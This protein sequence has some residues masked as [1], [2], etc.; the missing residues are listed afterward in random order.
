[1]GIHATVPCQE[2]HTNE[3]K[4]EF[5][6]LRTDCFG[7]HQTDYNNT[8]AP[9]HRQTGLGTD[10]Q[11]CHAVNAVNWG[12]SGVSFAGSFD[13]AKTGF[14]LLG[15]HA[16]T[17]CVQCHVGNK[18]LPISTT[19]T[20][21]HA[22][23]FASAAAPPH[24][25]FSTDCT[26]CHTMTSWIPATFDHNNT[27]F[28]LTG[29]HVTV[30]CQQCHVNNVFAG[31]T[32]TCY[33]CHQQQFTSA[34]TPVPHTGFPT[35]CTGCHTTNP[36]WG[37]SI[38]NHQTSSFPLVGAHV[39]LA[40]AQCH[41]NNQYVGLTT[42]CIGCHQV[43]FTN[44]AAPPHT[45]FATDCT[46]CHTTTVW[47]PAIFDHN[48]TPFPLTGGHTTVAACAT[49][50]VNNVYAGLSTAC[51][52]CHQAQFTTAT[53]PVAHT[54]FPTD[55]SGC[56][57]TNPGWGPSTFNHNNT[58]F[59][60][61]GGHTA[62]AAC[63][64]CH[65]NNVYAGLS[66]A[67]YSCHQAQFTTATTPVAHTGFPTDCSGCHT[68][69]P[70][71]GP[72]T[73]NH[74]TSSFPLVGAHISLAC[75]QCHIN[76]QYVGL[77]T[78][79]IGCH[80]V[81]FTNAAAPPH[82]GFATD[83]TTCHTTTVWQ[84]ATFDHNTTPFPL[85]GGHTTVAACVTCHVNNV[86]AGLSTACY[87]CHQ[88]QFTSATTPVPHTGFPTDCSGCHTTNPGWGPSTFNHQTSAFPLVGAH[89]SLTCAQCHINSQY[90]GLSTTCIGCHQVDFTNAASPPHT[91]F[92][93]DCTTCHSNTAWQPATFNHNTTPFPLTGAHATVPLCAT[94]HVNN[95]FAGL[96]TSC[97][98]CHQSQFTSATTPVPHTGFATDCSTCHTTNPGWGP[99][100]F[101]HNTMFALTG[102]HMAVACTQCHVSNQY[103]GL[104]TTCYGCHTQDF[105]TAAAPPHTGF[106]TDCTTCHTGG[107]WQPATFNHN[108]TP[109]PLTGGHATVACALCHVNNVFVGLTT[110]CYTCHTTTFTNAT[111]PV[112][113]TGFPTACA[114]CHTTNPG[115]TPSTFT[116]ANS[117]PRFPQDSRHTT[118]ACAKCHQ[119]ATNYTAY[120]CTNSG[121]HN[122][123]QGGD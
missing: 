37:P 3:Q 5:T 80:Q 12:V 79:C 24:T 6:G 97:Y 1:V 9:N 108:T 82:T 22:Q 91:G 61:T 35:D 46:T 75:A 23:V 120:C 62:V 86:Y 70:G 49:C 16:A 55:C 44:A 17:A 90:V 87:S 30:T 10:C 84:P 11:S 94:C 40:C 51:Y 85:T 100:T 71:W 65:V 119:T 42:T 59:P 29:G 18:F 95:V 2:C 68:T 102:A 54:G 88:T 114:T 104:A 78:T 105:S 63:A 48:N 101:N 31:L 56:H 4:N 77:T 50:H 53:T 7:C 89:V 109:F 73:F 58:P 115:W 38:F 14:P 76:N 45:G 122:S 117:T 72:S 25:G 47:Q 8:Q 110:D 41:I 32:T 107:A 13:H 92:P 20:A 99:S 33:N 69:N 121:C 21:C 66:T 15:A 118:A 103:V 98:N 36:G 93:N 43:D 67:C 19:C 28:P 57:T 60:L 112:P 39:S 83:C 34:T 96:S 52:S 74:Q 27:P 116:H 106:P 81:D 113:H 64:T 123:C 111:T 26:T